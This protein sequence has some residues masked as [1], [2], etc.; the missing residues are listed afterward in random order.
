MGAALLN[1]LY[2]IFRF[3]QIYWISR[4]VKK[5]TIPKILYRMGIVFNYLI[6]YSLSNYTKAH[7]VFGLIPSWVTNFKLL[8]TL[9]TDSEVALS[10][11]L[12]LWVIFL[13]SL[14]SKHVTLTLYVCYIELRAVEVY[15]VLE[16]WNASL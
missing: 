5:K 6:L 8:N 11:I 10:G 13:A 4:L 7:L 2:D 1:H 16:C 15:V 12:I 3:L 9:V 14:V